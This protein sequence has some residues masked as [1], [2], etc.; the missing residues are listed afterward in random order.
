M[1]ERMDACRADVWLW[2]ARFFKTRG[3]A[4]R[5]IEEGSVRLVSG[6]AEICLNK[7]GRALRLGDRLVVFLGERRLAVRVEALGERRGPATEARTL[8]CVMENPARAERVGGCDEGNSAAA[9]AC[10]S[11]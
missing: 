9:P 8:Y 1:A 3:L 11:G 5:M 10:P 7:P 6:A 4:A 2:R